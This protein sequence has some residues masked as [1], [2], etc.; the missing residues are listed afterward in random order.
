M[1]YEAS[2]IKVLENRDAVR[3][4]PGMYIGGTGAAGFHHLLWEIVDNGVDEA[5]GGH[6]STIHVTLHDDGRTITVQDDGRG[7]PVEVHPDKGVSTLEVVFTVLHAGGKFGGDSYGASGGLHGV[8]ASVVNFLSSK[9]V[10]E[11]RRA[12]KVHQQTF[13]QG[14]PNGPVSE[15]DTCRKNDTGTK[16]TFTPDPEMFGTEQNFDADLIRERLEIK[17][18]LNKGMRI[19]F[20][21]EVVGDTATYQHDGGVAEY[22]E[23]VVKD[24]KTPPVHIKPIVLEEE[25]SGVRIDLAF[26][27]TEDTKEDTRSFVNTIP[28]RSGGT[29]ESGFRSGM[30]AAVR[31]YMDMNGSAPKSLKIT[32]DDIREG[33]KAVVSVFFAG[34]MEIEGQ[35]KERLNNAEIKPIVTGVVKS[36]LEQHFL[37]HSSV[38]DKIM[39]R[40][41]QA[42]RAR[43]ASRSASR[44]VR[45]KK[46]VSKKL[47]LPGK[48]ADC[49]STDASISELFLVE[50]DSAG[51]CFSGDTKVAL[52]D[53]RHITFEELR[54]EYL[55]GKTNY[56]Y[57]ILDDGSV[58]V[59]KVTN[60]R[61]T[62]ADVDVVRVRIDNG[63]EVRCTPCHRFMLRDGT[64]RRAD[65]LVPGDSLMP[66]RTKL[67]QL[68]S[69]HQTLNGY[70]MIFDP[71]KRRWRYAHW[72]SDSYNL[73][74][75]TYTASRNQHRHHIDFNKLNNNPT[76]I[77][78]MD[79]E[80]HLELHRTT[81]D[82]TLHTE[83]V[84][85]R[86]RELRQTDEFREKMSAVMKE[87]G[88]LIS[89]RSKKQWQDPE[90][91]KYMREAWKTFYEENQEYREEVLERLYRE[92]EAYWAVEENRI[93][94][95]ERVTKYYEDNPEA[96]K[97]RRAEA[98][99]QW[100]DPELRKW[101]AQKTSEQWT[102][103]FRVQ[104]KKTLAKTYYANTV[105]GLAR[106]KTEDGVDLD[107]YREWR[108]SNKKRAHL[109][110][111]TFVNRYFD[112]DEASAIAAV[113]NHNHKVLSVT[114]I[115]GM[116]DVF[117][118]E[119]P[120]THNFALSNGIFVHNSAKQARD[121]E[122]QAILP[123]RGKILNTESANM[124]SI[125]KNKEITAIVEALGCGMD[126]KFDLSRLRYNKIILLM[127]ADS[128][129]HH[130]T[131]L[132][133]T[134]FYRYMPQLIQG[135]HLYLAQPPL[136]RITVGS[137]V[138]WAATE[139]EKNKILSETGSRT[140]DIARFKGLGEMM[141]DTLRDTTLNP[142]TRNLLQVEVPP[143]LEDETDQTIKALLGKGAS[144]RYA[145]IIA[146]L[147]SLES[148]DV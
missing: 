27:W 29:H 80:A 37:N 89:E 113:V 91:Q 64:Y 84:W 56:C 31:S 127:D 12:G 93:A 4:R 17:T 107:A 120:G 68:K 147:K 44:H 2:S 71:S 45:R 8:G 42:A 136:Y 94:Q 53:G 48:L 81:L 86:L 135:G 103:D 131:T 96:K 10:V 123:L 75:G 125:L 1:T 35:T 49:S 146:N 82:K 87:Q 110:F 47:T 25:A 99:E 112:G 61:K 88:H 116:E 83:E 126:D 140:V 26:Q 76:N 73:S 21:D 122:T 92:Q 77:T 52:A 6:A 79:K 51:G 14:T 138:H 100:E 62:K 16:V 111:S 132:L 134:F 130:I 124:K 63:E 129:G 148:V 145:F 108:V 3:Q 23:K 133:L 139:E 128:D 32:T 24:A 115:E 137:T 33:L 101:R 15:I 18:Y 119:V 102:E 104:R 46:P 13:T 121:R 66:F 34:D 28:T 58:G 36:Y 19:V 20:V 90:Y 72:I 70:L 143:D 67:S 118:L 41:V 144:D 54:A 59:E 141:K 97:E 65:S 60:V 117:D 105:A 109:M 50:G 43:E 142:S 9:M 74:R 55:E 22:L 98:L 95:S 106:F 40:I 78:R 7:I 30:V 39:E 11:V 85:D 57:T 38:A 69:G 5:I 114:P